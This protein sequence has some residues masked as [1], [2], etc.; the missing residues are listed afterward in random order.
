MNLRYAIGDIHGMLDALI[1]VQSRIAQHANRNSILHPEVIY[2]GD[3]IDRGPDSKSVIDRIWANKHWFRQTCL[4]GNHEVLAITSADRDVWL[5]NGGVE[6]LKSFGGKRNY[7]PSNYVSWIKSLP[8]F[9]RHGRWYFVHAGIDPLR[10]LDEQTDDDRLWIRGAFLHH[11]GPMP[12][13]VTVV[14]GHT[15]EF[16]RVATSSRIG[17]DQGA[18]FT[19]RE[20]SRLSCGV[21]NDEQ[22]VDILEVAT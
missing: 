20:N 6:T 3:Y 21:F 12:E 1:E 4:L 10:S 11:I 2:L 9:V 7:L 14:H 17:L 16:Q 18:C 5:T 22:L 8:T 13:G 19:H 15:V